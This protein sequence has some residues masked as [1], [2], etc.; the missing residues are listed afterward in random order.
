MP[1]MSIFDRTWAL[2]VKIYIFA[3]FL[4]KDTPIYGKLKTQYILLS[5]DRPT[6][7]IGVGSETG[8]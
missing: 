5:P 2:G 7:K 3:P 1:C 4:G 8:I 6:L